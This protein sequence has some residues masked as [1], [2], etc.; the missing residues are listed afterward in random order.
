VAIE[1]NRENYEFLKN[2]TESIELVITYYAALSSKDDIPMAQQITNASIEYSY[3][4][5]FSHSIENNSDLKSVSINKIITDNKFEIIDI[6]K[7]DIEGAEVDV[8]SDNTQ[9]MDKTKQI[10]IEIHDYKRN[11]CSKILIGAL[12]NKNFSI[13]FS[14]ENLLLTNLDLVPNYFPNAKN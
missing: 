12:L 2:Q 4:H 10:I 5:S 1:A 7:L 13:E 3:S 14:G 6:V 8:L 9:W 11:G